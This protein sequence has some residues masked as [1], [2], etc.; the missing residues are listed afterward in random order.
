MIEVNIIG[1]FKHLHQEHGLYSMTDNRIPLNWKWVRDQSKSPITIF[2]DDKM[3]D[4][5]LVNSIESKY[6]I[7][8]MIEPS[9]INNNVY[10]NL[11]NIIDN[12]DFILTYDKDLVQQ[13]PNKLKY[14]PYGGSWIF[15]P[16]IGIYEKSQNVNMLFSYKR[17]TNG[18]RLRHEIYNKI[19]N[20]D[21]FGS[22]CNNSFKYKEEILAPYRFSIV[23]ENSQIN[24][25]FSEK[26]LD[27]IALGTIPIYWGTENIGNYF[28]KEGI[29]SFNTIE[30]LQQILNT[31]T[32]ELYESKF[33][34]IQEN[35]DIVKKY[36][37]QEDWLFDNIFKY[38]DFIPYYK[39]IDYPTHHP[40]TIVNGNPQKYWLDLF[41][42]NG[43]DDTHLYNFKLDENSLIFDVGSYKGEY[44]DIMYKKY[45]CHIHAFEPIPQFYNECLL[46]KPN[47]VVLNN[48]ALGNRNCI[49]N[50]S[51]Q[52]NSSS[53]F[54]NNGDKIQCHKV[55]FNNY[56]EQYNINKIDL[57]KLNIEGGEYELLSHLI[58]HNNINKISN[59][60]IQFH[61]LEKNPI[62]ER[63]KIIN[64]LKLTHEL[65]F[66]YP[67]VWEYWRKKN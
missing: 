57:L 61:Y 60:L 45:N 63:E 21:Y 39:M 64:K 15:E 2:T 5:N 56:I 32:P 29:I 35:L 26:L 59:I 50:I 24:D 54:F 53:E 17:E 31:L 28:N 37:C 65:V 3:C 11:E 25:Y 20:V 33:N 49:F 10:N 47:K 67:F 48:F 38:L 40:N 9:E 42:N 41:F 36:Y 8:M 6:K 23:V 19:N 66:E 22:G 51:A 46:S 4:T 7:G 12:F 1:G 18:H 44:Y 62:M 34:A 16:Y 55:N 13:Y 30:E 43:G 52:D 27:T 14:Y 58:Y